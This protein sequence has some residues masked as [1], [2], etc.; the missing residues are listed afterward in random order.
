MKRILVAPSILSADFAR[1]GEEIE[2]ITEAGADM[3]HIDVM[4][5]CF[6][7]NITIGPDVIESIRKYTSLPFDVHLMVNSPEKFISQF[8]DAG[9]DYITVHFE[10][11]KHIDRLLNK[12]KSLGVKA[13]ISLLPSTSSSVLEYIIDY[14]DLILVMTVNPGFGGQ[15]FI[16]SQINKIRDIRSLLD[17]NLKRAILSVDGGVNDT[18]IKEILD[19]GADMLVAGSFIFSGGESQYKARIKKLN[20]LV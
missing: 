1:L 7:P 10:A 13:G 11:E 18:N 12:I 4:D 9:A 8:V 17:R 6:V 16:P 15:R 14:L 2:A 3:I 19:A 20:L 5:G